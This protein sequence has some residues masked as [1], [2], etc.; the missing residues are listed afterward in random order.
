M[1]H[2]P[3]KDNT[4]THMNIH[5]KIHLLSYLFKR[6]LTNVGLKKYASAIWKTSFVVPFDAVNAH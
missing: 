3:L 6:D 1:L 4:K 2:N 5:C